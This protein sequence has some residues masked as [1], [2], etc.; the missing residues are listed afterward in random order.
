MSYVL[1][2]DDG[3]PCSS[4][5]K[6]LNPDSKSPQLLILMIFVIESAA[7]CLSLYS[8]SAFAALLQISTV[9]LEISCLIPILL[10]LYQQCTVTSKSEL[11][12]GPFSLGSF[13]IPVGLLSALWLLYT[14]IALFLP[15][16]QDP[17]L[18]ITWAT[19]NYTCI[20]VGAILF[21]AGLF[22]WL[23]KSLGGVRKKF[24]GPQI[25]D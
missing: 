5:L 10:R 22:W 18:G 20:M 24:T 25:E 1:A 4:Y 16:R 14:T 3:L 13:S 2:R 9:G 19:F 21:L 15:Q 17:V 6:Y 23:P 8:T 7:C 12:I 11:A